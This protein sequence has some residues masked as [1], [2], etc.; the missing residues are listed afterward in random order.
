MNIIHKLGTI[1]YFL[2]AL[3]LILLMLYILEPS[4]IVTNN[5]QNHYN[6]PL[7]RNSIEKALVE[8]ALDLDITHEDSIDESNKN[9]WLSDSESEQKLIITSM[10]KQGMLSFAIIPQSP[11]KYR[12][13]I[14]DD[15]KCKQLIQL[16][17]EFTGI[18]KHDLIYREFNR[19]ITGRDS[20]KYGDTTWY[21]KAKDKVLMIQLKRSSVSKGKYQIR[22]IQVRNTVFFKETR[23]IWTKNNTQNYQKQVVPVYQN[24]PIKDIQKE[25]LKNNQSISRIVIEGNVTNT[26]KARVKKLE[27][28]TLE[29]SEFLLYAEDYYIA[30]ISDDSDTIEVLLPSYIVDFALHKNGKKEWHITYHPSSGIH[31]VDYGIDTH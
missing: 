13:D 7:T 29:N 24:V 16:A 1:K 25:L 19:Y 6:F 20:W 14:F 8:V 11:R 30:N 28:F 4:S 12:T 18:E 9:F 26:R 22:S 23:K 17:C 2:I 31:V 21:Y 15:D 27:E 3:G 5:S 10:K